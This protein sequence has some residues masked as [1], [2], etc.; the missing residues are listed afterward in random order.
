MN[1]FVK[2]LITEPNLED[3]PEMWQPPR[4]VGLV[5]IALAI[6][7]FVVSFVTFWERR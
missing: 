7:L 5:L 6:A 3:H 1:K 2:W 4:I